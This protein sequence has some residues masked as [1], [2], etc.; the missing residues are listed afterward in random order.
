MSRAGSNGPA[1]G[2]R[3][4]PPPNPPAPTGVRMWW[5]GGDRA[6]TAREKAL[7]EEHG[8]SSFSIPLVRA[9]ATPPA[10]LAEQQGVDAVGDQLLDELRDVEDYFNDVDPNPIHLA[11][12][13]AAISALAA[14][15]KQQ[16][17]EDCTATLSARIA[18]EVELHG[19]L[20]RVAKELGIDVGYLSR[21]ARGEKTNPS[22]EILEKFG[23]ERTVTYT[24]I[25]RK[26]A[27][28]P[29][30]PRTKSA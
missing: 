24:P 11:T 30:H 21:L 17:G 15:G 7:I 10:E 9:A 5:D 6:I 16:G 4:A 3:P 19:S 13:Q 28:S 20:Q 1:P 14:T 29:L 8:P 2:P 26:Y 25:K 18:F 12:V 22:D 27:A 23:L